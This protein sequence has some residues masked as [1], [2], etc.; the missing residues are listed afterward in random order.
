MST[1]LRFERSRKEPEGSKIRNRSDS[2]VPCSRS[3][4]GD[5][6]G[7]LWG[8][9]GAPDSIE[10][11][12]FTYNLR[13]RETGLCF[14]VYSGASGPA[15]GGRREDA[16]ALGP[17]LDSLDLLLDSS[18]PADCLIEY[19]TD[20]GRYAAGWSDGHPIDTPVTGR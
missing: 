14:S 15:Y 19:D 12:G 20:F 7:R 10:F 8:L 5:L 17:V 4:P 18:E 9:F 2:D 16:I 6:L 3:H 13:D 11:E 1:Q